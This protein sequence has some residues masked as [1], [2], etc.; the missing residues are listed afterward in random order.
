MG[1]WFRQKLDSFV[2]S[3]LVVFGVLLVGSTQARAKCF[4]FAEPA[5]EQ[6]L[7]PPKNLIWIEESLQTAEPVKW[8]RQAYVNAKTA[9]AG[10]VDHGL[11][12][13]EIPRSVEVL[14]VALKDHK[15]LKSPQ[16]T[17]VE[18]VESNEADAPARWVKNIQ[19]EVNPFP[20]IYVRWQERWGFY[21]QEVVVP[22]LSKPKK[23]A[24]INYEKVDGTSHISHLCGSIELRSLSEA[25]RSEITYYEQVRAT[26]RTAQDTLAGLRGTVE[27]LLKVTKP[28]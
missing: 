1:R 10:N 6:Q 8:L 19:F 14:M 20:L 23:M 26:N 17:I 21:L 11:L 15:N 25:N 2:V 27:T 16:A 12:R 28:K 24:L 7:Q 13:A 5:F 3:C 18:T 22:G 4:D 9:A